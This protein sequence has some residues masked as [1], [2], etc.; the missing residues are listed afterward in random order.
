MVPSLPSILIKY[1]P[2]STQFLE[3][4]YMRS[5]MCNSCYWTIRSR[6]KC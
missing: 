4:E 6:K 2:P 3:Y 1:P 5:W